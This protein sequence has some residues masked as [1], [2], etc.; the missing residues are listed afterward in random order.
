MLEKRPVTHR[1]PKCGHKHRL[2]D[3]G[4]WVKR[5]DETGEE[6]I[7]PTCLVCGTLMT[8]VVSNYKEL[9]KKW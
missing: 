4:V 6:D 5:K 9:L 2:T 7:F 3:W 8:M 1:C